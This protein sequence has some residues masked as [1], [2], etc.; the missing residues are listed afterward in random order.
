[1]RWIPLSLV[2]VSCGAAVP[3]W[4]RPLDRA[5]ALESDEP[6]RLRRALSIPRASASALPPPPETARGDGDDAEVAYGEVDGIRYLEMVF[7]EA[8]PDEPL[9]TLWIFHGRGDRARVPGGPFWDLPRPVRIFVPQA[10]APLGEGYSWLPYRVGEGRT[11]EL[12]AA[13]EATADRL[14]RIIARFAEERPT[15][16]RPIVTGFSQGGHLTYALALR[17]PEL[18]GYA[19]PNAGWLPPMSLPSLDEPGR[20]PPI[21]SLHGTADARVPHGPTA[22]LIEALTTAGL[23]ASLEPFEGVGHEM[24]GEMDARFRALLERALEHVAP[25]R[26]DALAQPVHEADS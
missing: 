2:L 11:A 22:A 12:A 26:L 17:H 25:A 19:L 20:F 8:D 9:V 18:V 4:P 23:D 6:R 5:I 24:T 13:L 16:G 21:R 10:P 1:M 7:G 14:A 15:A 3:S